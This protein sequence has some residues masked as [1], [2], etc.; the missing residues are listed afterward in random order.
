[1]YGCRCELST[2]LEPVIGKVDGV[3]VA[4]PNHTHSAVAR[5]A[6]ERGLP[7]LIE[8]PLTPL[9]A[10]A[11]ELCGLARQNGAFISVGFV[12]RH[13][14]VVPL[15]RRLLDEGFFGRVISFHF[16]YGTRGGWAPYSGYNLH[17]AQSGGGVLVVSGTHFLDRMLFWFGTPESF[18][19]A[20]DSYGGVEA[21][22]KARMEFG[23]G[24]TG[25]LFFSKTID[26]ANRFVMETDRYRIVIPWSQR[27][28]IKLQD[29]ALPGIELTLEDSGAANDNDCFQV[30]L[31]EFARVI[32]EGGTPTVSGEAG[33]LSVKLCEDFYANR[34]QLEEPWI[35]YHSIPV[36]TP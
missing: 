6:L 24:V 32:R 19:Y 15:M 26:L 25:T 18:G 20:D 35:R 14:P 27:S 23:G 34:E 17:R 16:E 31:E 8:K 2:A 21:N 13:Y 9:Y 28:Q 1:M 4:T 12:T 22:C 11:M 36:S 5:V 10:E 29:H 33:A 30:Q 3:L 7:V